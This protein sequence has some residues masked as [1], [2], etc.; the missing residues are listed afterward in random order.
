MKYY[1]K[2][3][4]VYAFKKDGSQDFL[5]TSEFIPMTS[6][7]IDRHINPEN[8]WTDE[9]K[10]EARLMQFAPLSRRQ[11]KR[12]LRDNGLLK[13]VEDKIKQIEDI[14]LQESIQIDYDEADNFERTNTSVIYMASMLELTTE[15]LD[16]LWLYALKL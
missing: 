5:I 8:Y 3:N 9:Q 15:Q 16:N 2:Y 11:F 6:E 13:T 10:E 4:E 12:T 1:K 7:E 14:D